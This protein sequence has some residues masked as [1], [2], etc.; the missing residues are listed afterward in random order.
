MSL[1]KIQSED[2]IEMSLKVTFFE[3]TPTNIRGVVMEGSLRKN[4]DDI[5]KFM[6]L[7]GLE[8]IV[9]TTKKPENMDK[10]K[11]W[12]AT[13]QDDLAVTNEEVKK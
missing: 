1:K 6:S 4:L 2:S 9:L 7:S 8:S 13:S 5:M 10:Y 3:Q 11:N 12:L